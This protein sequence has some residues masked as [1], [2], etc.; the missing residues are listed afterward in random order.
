[1]KFASALLLMIL[2]GACTNHDIEP[3]TNDVDSDFFWA[4]MVKVQKGDR[5]ATLL[6]MDP[7]PLSN[8]VAPGPSNPDYFKI[9]I[10]EDGE[11]FSLHK[12][13]DIKTTSVEVDGLINSK[14]YYFYVSAHKGDETLETGKL[15]TTPSKEAKTERYL[16]D[17]NFRMET[18]SVS[19]DQ[20][21]IAYVKDN[22][23]YY[24]AAA[25]AD[26]TF[27]GTNAFNP[28][29]SNTTNSMLYI[30]TKQEGFTIYPYEIKFLDTNSQI[31]STLLQINYT[32]YYVSN[33]SFSPDGSRVAF[34]SSEGNSEKY[35]YDLWTIIP[36]TG[37]K[38]RLSNFD[39]A[40][41]YTQS[42]Y[43]WSASGSSVYLQGRFNITD[44]DDIFKFDIA[45]K[46]LSPV[47]QSAWNE[48]SP[49]LS[50]DQTKIAFVS[51]RTGEN[52]LWLYDL[53]SETYVQITGE[54]SYD[55]DSRYTNL[56][57]LDNNQMLIT[58]YKN[59]QWFPA[60][61]NVE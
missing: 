34:L 8:Y 29:W 25:T 11:N 17:L 55:F 12:K 37:E 6:L 38:T 24:Q 47:I 52:E 59:G 32:D 41:F 50:P 27:L 1:M 5:K 10:S 31:S 21:Y 46:T 61:I 40:G 48:A 35:I 22:A 36:G 26:G 13:I 58:I 51:D 56:T 15:M 54:K 30:A 18:V 2:L 7:R 49:S 44:R 14:H 45:T 33:P 42:S 53:Q 19:H 20:N 16:P 43:D 9:W 4:P 23:L 3:T 57:W 28:R 39:A 60:T